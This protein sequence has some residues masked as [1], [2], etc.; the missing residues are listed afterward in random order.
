M[1]FMLF[2]PRTCTRTL[3]TQ[4]QGPSFNTSRFLLTCSDQRLDLFLVVTCIFLETATLF[5]SYLLSQS[6]HLRFM[7][8][9]QGRRGP[10]GTAAADVGQDD[11]RD[12]TPSPREASTG[13]EA[14]SGHAKIK[15]AVKFEV[16]F[17]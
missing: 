5:L 1:I 4:S 14:R 2:P 3:Q 6:F 10:I 16:L 7:T 13:G 17:S 11:S 12:A 9:L 8:K 15:F